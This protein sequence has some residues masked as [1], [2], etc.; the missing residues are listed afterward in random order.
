MDSKDE[1]AGEIIIRAEKMSSCNDLVELT[2]S[3]YNI[4]NPK[5]FGN[6]QAFIRIYRAQANSI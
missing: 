1:Q 5:F 4:P 2:L 3:L 6:T